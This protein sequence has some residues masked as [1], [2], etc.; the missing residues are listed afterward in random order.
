MFQRD[1]AFGYFQ[2]SGKNLR[3]AA[4]AFPS[5]C[6]GPELDFNRA[7]MLSHDAVGFRVWNDVKAES[8]H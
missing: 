2:F 5:V 4:F 3:S 7:A 1:L 8:R 6:R